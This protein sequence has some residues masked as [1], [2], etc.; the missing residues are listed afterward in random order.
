MNGNE[1]TATTAP[2]KRWN[3]K[4]SSG[5]HNIKYQ[6]FFLL[7]LL[8]WF[9]RLSGRI[10]LC[11]SVCVFLSTTHDYR[12]TDNTRMWVTAN[13]I[14]Y[15]SYHVYCWIHKISFDVRLSVYVY[16]PVFDTKMS[17]SFTFHSCHSCKKTDQ[18]KK[19]NELILFHKPTYLGTFMSVPISD[20]FISWFFVQ[21][22]FLLSACIA[23]QS[24]M[25]K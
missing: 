24:L 22:P 6:C 5:K 16:V 12:V 23:S 8:N 25:P 2:T 21:H 15:S 1:T 17:I 18:G 13:K 11:V 14:A 7:S 20:R 19:I 9:Y 3:N 10:I 4:E